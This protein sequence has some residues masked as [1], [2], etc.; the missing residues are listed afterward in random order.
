M[1][2]PPPTVEAR[3]PPSAPSL[4]RFSHA[5]IIAGGARRS[6]PVKG[7]LELSHSMEG[8]AVN[9]RR[10]G[11]DQSE[12]FRAMQ[13]RIDETKRYQDAIA[14]KMRKPEPARQE[15][16]TTLRAEQE[17]SPWGSWAGIAACD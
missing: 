11:M 4:L 2:W 7:Y 14:A 6:I 8:I 13:R 16:V 3:R 17:Q 10:A 5:P 9:R 12:E 15:V 1:R